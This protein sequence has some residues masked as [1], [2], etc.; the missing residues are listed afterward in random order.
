M[1]EYT[2]AKKKMQVGEALRLLTGIVDSMEA[3]G[4]RII[5]ATASIEPSILIFTADEAL[6]KWAADNELDIKVERFETEEDIGLHWL[7]ITEIS[8]VTV[9]GYMSDAEKEAW[10][11]E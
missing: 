10:D 2:T 7:L 1:G 5:N 4:I 11:A 3:A 9:R 6:R 8:G